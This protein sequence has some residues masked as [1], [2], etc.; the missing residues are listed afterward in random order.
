[1]PAEVMSNGSGLHSSPEQRLE[2]QAP[3]RVVLKFGGWSACKD[4]FPR[5]TD[6]RLGTSIG[7]FAP[8]IA[9]ICLYFR[10]PAPMWLRLL[11]TGCASQ[12]QLIREPNCHRLLCPKWSIKG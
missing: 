3:Q 7:K 11:L 12:V 2:K 4:Y 1:M 6:E 8:E 5:Q 10:A 9:K